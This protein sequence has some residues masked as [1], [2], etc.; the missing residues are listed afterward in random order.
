MFLFFDTE[1]SGLWRETLDPLDPSQPDLIQIGAKLF[2]PNWKLAGAVYNLIRPV[3]W[4]IEPEAQ[5]VHGISDGRCAKYGVR[6]AAA[7]SDFHDLTEN[8]RSLVGHHVFF[9]WRV[10]KCAIHRAGGEGLWWQKVS[11]RLE[12]TMELATPHCQLPGQF[13]SFKFPSLDEAHGFFF[14]D[15]PFKAAHDANADLDATVSI[16][17]AIKERTNANG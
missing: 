13:G 16:Y 10:I 2:D 3:G 17:R 1:T 6:L 11:G 7:L 14:P 5:A 4:S 15:R 9:D 8:S 12:C